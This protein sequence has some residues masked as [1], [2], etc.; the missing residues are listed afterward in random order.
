MTLT[1][2]HIFEST[3][4]RE[5]EAPATSDSVHVSV[6]IRSINRRIR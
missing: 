4:P 3:F 2:R 1:V 6:P 5:L